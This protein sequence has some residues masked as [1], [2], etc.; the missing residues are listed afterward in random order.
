VQDH[1]MGMA[2]PEVQTGGR[3]PFRPPHGHIR[4]SVK[5]LTRE[6]RPEAGANS[7]GGITQRANRD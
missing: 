5:H 4:P 6:D 2:L 7:A 1:R 3:V